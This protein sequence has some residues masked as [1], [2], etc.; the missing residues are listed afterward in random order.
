MP[1]GPTPRFY[2]GSRAD[3][4][5]GLVRWTLERVT[6]RFSSSC[7]TMAS[8][9]SSAWNL[10]RTAITTARSDIHP[11]IRPLIRHGP[12]RRKEFALEQFQLATC[13]QTIEHVYD[14]LALCHDRRALSARLFGLKS[15][16]FDIEHLQLFS[17]RS[18]RFVL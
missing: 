3:F 1:V 10:P 4:R 6:G 9:R 12:F 16:N 7:L 13:F 8:P 14:P 5:A 11:R 2:R 18:I 15:P 17:A